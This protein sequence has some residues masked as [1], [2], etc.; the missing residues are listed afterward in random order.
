MSR[1]Y[2]LVNQKGG[3]G[4]T[5]T[6]INLGA[7]LAEAGQRVLL[8]DL[9]PQANAT[10]CLGIRYADVPAGTYDALIGRV[11]AV[12]AVLS[13][14]RLHMSLLPSSPALAGAQVELV[15]MEDREQMLRQAL[16]SVDDP[17]DYVLIDCPPSLGILTVNG[18][19]AARDGVIIP[20]QCEY[21]AL[22]G[23]TQLI[24]TLGRV[25]AHLFP[26]LKI[27]GLVLTMFD[28]RTHLSNDVVE[29]VRKHFPGQVFRSIIPRTVRLAEAP[30]HG[31]PISVYDRSSVGATA[32][33]ALADEL[34]RGD[35][36]RHRPIH[37]FDGE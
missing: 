25:R 33:K 9:D 3:V 1:M 12:D 2:T 18:L 37:P 35:G 10:A 21:L 13:N 31:L 4:K 32:Y 34:L 14:P 22:E 23:L 16:Q 7:Y 17:F 5:T 6:A 19:L 30:S 24:S 20:V 15:G 28:S 11:R 27:R 26:E 29:E 36:I 8:V